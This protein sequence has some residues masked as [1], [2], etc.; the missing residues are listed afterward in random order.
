MAMDEWQALPHSKE[1]DDALFL[2]LGH[3]DGGRRRRPWSE[4]VLATVRVLRAHPE[5][6]AKVLSE[7]PTRG[8]R[9][10]PVR[11]TPVRVGQ[12]WQRTGNFSDRT[13]RIVDVVSDYAYV[14]PVGPGRPS[15]M[16]LRPRVWGGPTLDGYRLIEDAA[17][18]PG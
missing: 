14:E 12:V 8:L 1:Y 9:G 2:L 10:G 6:A 15:R 17:D 5:L 16:R 3:V 7:V 11:P 4:V 13:V 18:G